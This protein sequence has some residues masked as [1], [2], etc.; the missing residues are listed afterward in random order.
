VRRGLDLMLEYGLTGV[1]LPE[2]V[3]LRGIEQNEFH[4]L[5][6]YEHTL[7]VLDGVALLQRDPLSVGLDEGVSAL[8]AQ[9]FSDEITRGTAMRF[10]ALLHDAAKPETRAMRPDGRVTFIGHDTAG[11]ALA[12]RVME[13]LRTSAKLRE[14]V[15]ALVVHHLSLGFLVHREPLERRTIWRYI[16]ATSPYTDDVT[17]FTV[18]DRLATRGRNAEAA[19]AA[20]IELARRMLGAEP[21]GEPLVTGD[22]LIRELG[23]RPGPALGGVLGALA[24]AQYAGEIASREEALARARELLGA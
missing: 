16:N 2:L 7:A 8:L 3:E 15:G 14:Y 1:V 9:P 13:R 19:I 11:Q 4:H 6:V 5:D 20:H 10:A 21:P 23:V 17:I 24:E 22:D 12:R 18:A